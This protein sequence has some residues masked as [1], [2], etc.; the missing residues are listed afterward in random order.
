MSNHQLACLGFDSAALSLHDFLPNEAAPA[1]L[2]ERSDPIAAVSR[3]ETRMYLGNTLLRDGDA[4]GMANSL[5]IRVPMLDRP[6]L[7]LLHRTPGHIRLPAGLSNKH[8]L[9]KAFPEYIRPALANRPKSGFTLPVNSWLLGPLHDLAHQALRS[10]KWSG[11]VY[12]EGVDAIWQTF[13]REPT[14]P[15]WSRALSLVV[16]GYYISGLKSGLPEVAE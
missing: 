7:D 6:V 9:R 3:F 14:S 5:E 8:L 10:L 2:C 15:I 16:L 13:L 12:S 11:V 1:S 4:N